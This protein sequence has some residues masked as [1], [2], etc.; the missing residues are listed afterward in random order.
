M[1]GYSAE[2]VAD[3]ISPDGIRLTTMLTRYPRFIHSEM[4]RHRVFSHSVAS[5]R[6]IPTEQ[7]IR[8]VV[9][10]PFVPETFNKRIKGMGVGDPLF[11]VDH[12]NAKYLWHKAIQETINC[13]LSLNELNVDKSRVNRL[14]EPFMWVAD[15][16]T[17]TEWSNFF[18]LRD[19]PDA[20]PEFRI[21]AR[22]MREA[23]DASEPYKLTYGEWHLPLVPKSELAQLCDF[24]L[25]YGERQNCDSVN[26][27]VERWKY[28]SAGRCARV[29]YDKQY[30]EEDHE[31]SM[32]RAQLLIESGHMSPFEHVA[33]SM[34]REHLSRGLGDIPACV[35][36]EAISVDD[37]RS[38]VGGDCF[39]G[40]F[41]GW[42]Q[43]RKGITNESDF[44]KILVQGVEP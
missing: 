18:A 11:G 43:M 4:L 32:A 35:V 28:I 27:E 30:E 2:I 34:S 8:Q 40:N 41:R 23:M 42:V 29:S 10:D 9:D 22:M 21:I 25:D 13:A 15:F 5:S 12:D 39:C 19:H 20:Q 31:R 36:D 14:L 38:I 26:D 37:I 44:S 24:R 1:T 16:I 7:L 6:A 17:A 33:T 3:S